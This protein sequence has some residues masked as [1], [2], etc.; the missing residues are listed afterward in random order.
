M[1]YAD[2]KGILDRLIAL[3]SV[4]VLSPLFVFVALCILID[5]PGGALFR[6]ER[7]GKNGRKF[8][9][10]KFR[11]M[12]GTTNSDDYR[13]LLQQ[14]VKSDKP[15]T[16]YKLR[17]QPRVT[18]VGGFLRKTNL[19]ELPQLFNV[20]KGDLSLV[21]PRPDLPDSVEFYEDW[22]RKR[23]LVTPGMTGL[24]QVSGGNSLLFSDMVRLDIKYIEQRSLFLDTKIIL[25]TVGIVLRRDGNY[26]RQN[27]DGDCWGV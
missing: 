21:G 19:D 23:L 17:Y 8:T 1:R 14:L 3:V 26:W 6:Q 9:M 22:M 4:L 10:Y 11:S 25:Q 13:E 2:T 20:F 15:H 5:S 12:H 18:R 27:R 7:V 16:F 24:W